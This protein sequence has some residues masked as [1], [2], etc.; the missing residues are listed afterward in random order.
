MAHD[1]PDAWLDQ[2]EVDTAEVP[3]LLEISERFLRSRLT[4]RKSRRRRG[5]P[6]SSA[7]FAGIMDGDCLYALPP[8]PARS[9]ATGQRALSS[10]PTGPRP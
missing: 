9:N 8:L 7:H 3:T 10:R 6:P 2:L 4:R 5:C 1:A